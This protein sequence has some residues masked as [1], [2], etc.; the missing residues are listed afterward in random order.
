MFPGLAILFWLLVGCAALLGGVALLIRG[1]ARRSRRST[2]AGA[3]L[4]ACLALYGAR[5]RVTGVD[6]WNPVPVRPDALVGTWTAGASRLELHPD[7][8]F[9]IDARGGA[10]RRVYLTR[11]EGEWE[12]DD[13]NLTLRPVGGGARELRVVVANGAYRIIEQPGDLDGWTSWRGFNRR[14][15]SPVPECEA[16]R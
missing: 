4:L 3:G 10:A 14:P 15:S 9:R 12:V 1:T 8:T 16:C 7:G 2:L 13:Y 6:Q 11:A 5:A